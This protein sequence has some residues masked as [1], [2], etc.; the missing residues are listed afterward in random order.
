MIKSDDVLFL[1]V[2][3]KGIIAYA[4]AADKVKPIDAL[5]E[6]NYIV[7]TKTGWHRG[8]Y[9][10]NFSAYGISGATLVGGQ[11][12]LVKKVSRE[13]AI[14]KLFEMEKIKE[15]PVME[16]NCYQLSIA[17]V[18]SWTNPSIL[19]DS[20][21]I[22][23]VPILQRGLVWSPQQ[24]ELLWDSLFRRIPIGAMVLCPSILSQSRGKPCTHHILDG[25]QRTNAISLG[26]DAE[27]FTDNNGCAGNKSILWLDVNPDMSEFEGTSR[28]FMFRVTT[29]AH[30]WGYKYSDETGRSACLSVGDIRNATKRN[31]AAIQ[32]DKK[33]PYTSE[34]YPWCAH[35]PIPMGYLMDAYL[36]HE[37]QI[38]EKVF[39]EDVA[40]R[41]KKLPFDDLKI[42]LMNFFAD[43]SESVIAKRSAI[44]SGLKTALESVVIA[45]NAPREIIEDTNINESQ[46]TIENL[47]TRINRQGTRLDGEELVYSSIKSYWPEIED[48]IDRCAKGRMASSRMLILGLRLM[49][50]EDKDNHYSASISISRI[51]EIANDPI[52]RDRS[53]SLIT[54]DLGRLCDIVDNWL[55]WKDG[56]GFP[57]VLKTAI[58]HAA[59]EIYLFLLALALHNANIERRFVIAV[60]TLLY[61][62]DYRVRSS[63]RER[64][65]RHILGT[66]YQ[67]GFNVGTIRKA[68]DECMARSDDRW[69]LKVETL[70]AQAIT[71]EL[72]TVKYK[73]DDLPEETTWW[74][75]FERFRCSRDMLLLAEAEYVETEFPDYDPARKDLWA[76]YN[77]PWDYDHIVAQN[78]VSNWPESKDN[79]WWLWCVGNF[80][81]IPLEENRSKSDENDWHYY[82]NCCEQYPLIFDVKHFESLCNEKEPLPLEFRRIVWQRFLRIYGVLVKYIQPAIGNNDI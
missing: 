30:P 76:E 20:E 15:L 1:N 39:W 69:M 68:I 28:R 27:P 32:K 22:A 31:P 26:F 13:W 55:V 6:W 2:R 23:Q 65:V 25:Q 19:S 59:P 11:F 73:V 62:F 14:Q 16:K 24:N 3:G 53:L 47:F 5:D 67:A 29:P 50:T 72:E 4:I 66:C 79:S 64:V 56:I 58:A 82:H 18:A 42:T 71:D 49:E 57:K 61:F 37:D 54:R 44:F 74:P 48:S 77:R 63:R 51:R 17:D 45:V 52:A 81:A 41:C 70:G 9:G 43:T 78:T 7:A 33:R 80:A 46:S 38:T 12:S 60:A 75:C 34:I 21:V 35:A 8:K 40:N 36:N 10:Q